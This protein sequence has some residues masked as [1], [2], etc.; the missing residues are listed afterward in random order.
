MNKLT[1]I[2]T[3]FLTGVIYA[4][5]EEKQRII[6]Q[7]IE[8]IG[9]NL[10]DSDIDF[11]TYFDDLFL[12]YDEPLNLNTATFEEL[13]RLH[14]LTDVQIQAII[15]YRYD[16]GNYITVYELGSIEEL[17]PQTIEMIL[18]FVRVE[19]VEN[20]YFKWSNAFKYGKH[21][22]IMRYERVLQTKEG[23]LPKPDSV[24]AENPNKSYLGSPDKLYLRYRNR[25][26]DRLSWGIT[27]EKDAGEELFRGSQP[28]GFDYYS[29][30]L[31]FKDLWKFK[32][33]ALGDFQVNVGQGLTMWSSFALGKSADVFSGKR[34][35]TGIRPY[36]SVNESRF[37]RGGAFAFGNDHWNFMGFASYKKLD[38]NILEADSI[39]NIF[40][41]RFSSFQTSGYHR[42]PGELEDKNALQEFITGG[43][44][45]YSGKKFRIGWSGVFT[46]YNQALQL[47]TQTY[48]EFKFNGSQL[49]TTGL[50]YRY[51][52]KKMVF[53]GETALSENMKMGT[54]NGVSWQADPR[55]DILVIH[56]FYDK[57]FQSIYSAAFGE[58]SD[59]TGENGLYFGAQAR[60]TKW[61][62]VSAFYDQFQHT[63]LKW[64]TDDMS[65]GRDFFVQANFKINR[66]NNFYIRYK[67][68]LT[69]RNGK[70]DYTGLKQQ[71]N[72]VKNQFRVHFDH[73][74]NSQ[75]TLKSRVEWVRFKYDE[76]I[77]DGILVFQDIQYRF[78]KIPLKLYA[79]YALFDTDNYDSRIYAYE[80]D[81]LYVFSIPSYYYRGT[82]T[83]FMAKYEIGSKIDF[84]IRYGMWNYQ[85][86][87]N[88][89][90]GLEEIDGRIKSDIKLQIKIRI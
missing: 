81:L 12:Y 31:Y 85:N 4:Q 34:F 22:T 47:G 42:T 52:H 86:V 7:R 77:G 74:I 27:M 15:Q 3:L 46:Q 23:Y 28:Y 25:Y 67:N 41:D 44:L 66:R 71:V 84:W 70:D 2:I 90:S 35:A 55:L 82:R 17:G 9:E 37:L 62:S 8:F 1:L 45:S 54:M 21:E 59:N 83:Y 78:R 68:R 14:L 38:A 43:E 10:E 64:L 88:I 72:L 30:H 51:Y 56:R 87:D 5:E 32:E 20:D 89:S 63:Y 57:A 73:D 40:E 33:L 69:E 11:T 18:P 26:K 19:K 79:R 80:N 53:F 24:L 75:I 50:N 6:E 65:E 39:N 13:Q 58:S 48:K 16:Y 36:T 29:G 61:L 49:F 76:N 60:V